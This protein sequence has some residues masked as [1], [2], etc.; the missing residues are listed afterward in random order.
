MLLFSSNTFVFS[1]SMNLKIKMY[2]IIILPVVIYDCETW[3][4]IL[5]EERRLRVFES[6]ILRRIFEPK[7]GKNGS[8]EG[9]TMKNFIV[10]R[11]IKFRR[12]RWTG[13]T[14]SIQYV[15]GLVPKIKN[16]LQVS[17]QLLNDLQNTFLLH[18]YT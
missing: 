17:L 2:K 11:V 8:A 14:G 6:R 16:L 4:L 12:V 5:R 18:R 1:T 10:V 7:R 9:F 13:Y 3:S 15:S